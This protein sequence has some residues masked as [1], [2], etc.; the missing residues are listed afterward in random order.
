M[1]GVSGRFFFGCQSSTSAVDATEFVT[2]TLLPAQ[3]GNPTPAFVRLEINAFHSWSGP[4]SHTPQACFSVPDGHL[5]RRKVTVR[6]GCHCAAISD[7][8]FAREFVTDTCCPAHAGQG[9]AH[10][11][12]HMHVELG[13][14][15]RDTKGRDVEV[16]SNAS[17]GSSLIAQQ[18]LLERVTTASEALDGTQQHMGAPDHLST[19]DGSVGAAIRTLRLSLERNRVEV[20]VCSSAGQAHEELS[21]HVNIVLIDVCPQIAPRRDCQQPAFAQR[22]ADHGAAESAYC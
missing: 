18:A 17:Q 16:V 8:R 21:Q 1:A 10:G 7:K 22:A 15:G 4:R 2:D 9:M 19:T 20:F 3:H 14:A 12:P 6:V 11:D 5:I 13:S